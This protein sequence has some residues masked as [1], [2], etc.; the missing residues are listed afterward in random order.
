M[1]VAASIALAFIAFGLGLMVGVL[2][3]SPQ[4]DTAYTGEPYV[5]GEYYDNVKM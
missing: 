5:D 1:S 4:P 2:F 3:A